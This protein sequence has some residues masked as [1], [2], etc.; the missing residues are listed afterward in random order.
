MEKET[1][2]LHDPEELF[3]VKFKKP[4]L[5]LDGMADH[6]PIYQPED[7]GDEAEVPPDHHHVIE[8]EEQSQGL[9][10]LIT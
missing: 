3:D 4:K 7:P 8:N 1:V 10:F 2:F 9:Y 5:Q 6:E